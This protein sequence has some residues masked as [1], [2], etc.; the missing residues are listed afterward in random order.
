MLVQEPFLVLHINTFCPTGIL[1]TVVL[2]L[3]VAKKAPL[4]ETTVQLP[5]PIESELA[6]I[7]AGVP[8]QM[9]WLAPATAGVGGVSAKIDMVCELPAAH[10]LLMLHRNTLRP[11]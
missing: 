10:G 6:P 1:L 7:T 3:V 5:V 8:K 4:P 2:G 11:N 9:V